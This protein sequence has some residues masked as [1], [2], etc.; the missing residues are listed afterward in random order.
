M[1]G[2]DGIFNRVFVLDL[3][4]PDQRVRQLAQFLNGIN[5]AVDRDRLLRSLGRRNGWGPFYPI[6]HRLY[7]LKIPGGIND[8]QT[9]RQFYRQLDDTLRTFDNI[10]DNNIRNNREL[11]L[12]A[13]RMAQSIV[14][15]LSH[16]LGRAIN[17]DLNREGGNQSPDLLQLT[18]DIYNLFHINI[19][20]PNE[21]NNNNYVEDIEDIFEPEPE[22]EPERGQEHEPVAEPEERHLP[23]RIIN[24]IDIVRNTYENPQLFVRALIPPQYHDRLRQNENLVFALE[25][26]FRQSMNADAQQWQIERG[27]GDDPAVFFREVVLRLWNSMNILHLHNG[28]IRANRQ[29][30]YISIDSPQ[31]T[32]TYLIDPD[33]IADLLAE[34]GRRLEHPGVEIRQDNYASDSSNVVARA[35][36][37]ATRVRF[38]GPE[39]IYQI[40]RDENGHIIYQEPM[41]MARIIRRPLYN[42]PLRE[43]RNGTMRQILNMRPRQLQDYIRRIQQQLPISLMQNRGAIFRPQQI[44]NFE[45]Q[46]REVFNH[47]IN[48]R[49][50]RRYNMRQGNFFPF[51]NLTKYDL[52]RYQIPKIPSDLESKDYEDCCLMFALRMSGELSETELMEM[53]SSIITR[54]LRPAKM[55]R[56]L[57][58]C[59][60]KL[61]VKTLR[62]AWL[63]SKLD[64][65]KPPSNKY[66]TETFGEG[67]REIHVFLI[68]G[69]F[70]LDEPTPITIFSFG[71]REKI[72]KLFPKP[73]KKISANGTQ[74]DSNDDITQITTLRGQT[75]AHRNN[76]PGMM[77]SDLLTE[78][79]L[80]YRQGKEKIFKPM[81]YDD[82][83]CL[84]SVAFK[85]TRKRRRNIEILDR[86][87]TEPI[88]KIQQEE[89]KTLNYTNFSVRQL[90][91]PDTRLDRKKRQTIKAIETQKLRVFYADFESCTSNDDGT[92]LDAHIPFMCCVRESKEKGHEN[93]CTFIG[94]NSGEALFD[95]VINLTPPDEIPLIYFHNLSYD[96]NFLLKY[97]IVSAVNRN[98]LI[99]QAE[100]LYK[101]RIIRL[102]DSYGLLS[103]PLRSMARS[104]K[105]EIEKEIF[106]YSY[107]SPNRVL[108]N[109]GDIDDVYEIENAWSD[110]DKKQFE[111]NLQNMNEK[112]LHA[113]NMVKYAQFYCERD[114]DVL[115]Q[116]IDIFHE[117][118]I[119][120]FYIDCHR[121]ISISSIADKYLRNMV[122]YPFG[123]MFMY[124]NH[125]RDF[126]LD[127]V[128]GGR[129]MCARNERHHFIAQDREHGLWDLDAVSLYPSAM[130]CLYTV[131]GKPIPLELYELDYNY[132]RSQKDITAYV[133]EIYITAIN[134]PR[135]F[136]LVIHKDPNTGKITNTN[137]APVRMTV[138][139]IELEDLVEFQQ[140]EF[141]I[142]RGLKWT[143]PRDY[144]IQETVRDLFNKR[145]AYKKEKNPLENSYKLLLNSIYG[146][147][148]Q[149]A[150]D[151]EYKYYKP[152]TNFKQWLVNHSNR[153]E[154]FTI[155]K[156]SDIVRIK[157]VMPIHKHFNNTLLGVQILAMSKRLMNRVM[158]LADDF[159]LDV[160]YQDTDSMHIRRD[161]VP[162]LE[163][164]F[165]S[166][167][168]RDLR[169]TALCQ[170][171]PDFD[172]ICSES[173][174]EEVT[175][176][177]SYFLGKKCYCDKLVDQRGNI[178]YHV[179]MKGVS[180]KSV[181]HAAKEDYMGLYARLFSGETV[182]FDLCC[183]GQVKFDN[184][185]DGTVKT[186][187]S[188]ER[189]VKAT[190][191][192]EQFDW[193]ERWEI[194]ELVLK[195]IN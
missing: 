26:L 106:P 140:I 125:I 15:R 4:A 155:I 150:I 46:H 33:H 102:K 170:F 2:P 59:N 27:H 48:Q 42:L 142:I 138:C 165:A 44:T 96:I 31:E 159:H 39:T 97:G 24:R 18:N 176:I 58:A 6:L 152:D 43:N 7:N 13:Q 134:K 181:A 184:T 63:I 65:Q 149:K 156:D 189:A 120:S 130:S 167:Y 25:A 67:T 103:M 123:Q 1:E 143:G 166:K 104:F 22:P 89:Y 86:L 99:L 83:S 127:A 34:L 14:Y 60:I 135:D 192:T 126:L 186:K 132:L 119:S 171:H 21:N 162:V 5:D 173:I 92:Y 193:D 182:V 131:G 111:T 147:T 109:I 144:T 9:R 79:Y 137:E 94:T 17:A 129:V 158:C 23:P 45:G 121:V 62:E 53:D 151:H 70:I 161:Q 101:G 177:E 81:R 100:F 183:D 114:V 146:K 153:V 124:S 178:G 77:S 35:M 3:A 57:S 128:H 188:F 52:H 163:R 108:R 37:E 98:S 30:Y 11:S 110:D 66:V 85:D 56:F 19:R 84:H 174:P 168:G 47:L 194:D 117:Q 148:I 32:K 118:V 12:R 61:Y 91:P 51:F 190:A 8:Y 187:T 90:T 80:Q 69:H 76:R 133:V 74:Y 50:H 88:E 55:K 71:Q 136:P 116:C 38:G 40:Q 73:T 54:Q 49:G 185:K 112:D 10:Y 172:P 95:W 113:F 154:N 107:Y 191:E 72:N 68:C 29:N 64:H 78:L 180:L 93:K 141:H 160:Y 20:Q 36:T 169:G 115:Q 75:Y 82:V 87:A 28:D 16:T 195:L 105:I 164:A 145:A 175:A 122:Y 41:M 157:E 179:R 139:D